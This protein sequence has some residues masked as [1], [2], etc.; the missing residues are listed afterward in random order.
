MRRLWL[1]A[2]VA[3]SLVLPVAPRCEAAERL[4]EG[5]AATLGRRGGSKKK[6]NY[7]KKSVRVKSCRT[8]KGKVVK[9]HDRA[10]PTR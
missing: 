2:L 3:L 8:Q 1:A 5:E 4:G 6:K 9:P 7:R 10:A